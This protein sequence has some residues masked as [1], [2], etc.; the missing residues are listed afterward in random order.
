M[1]LQT[2]RLAF[3]AEAVRLY[4][5]AVEPAIGARLET[6]L[7]I[8]WKADTGATGSLVVLTQ[9]KY[10]QLLTTPVPVPVSQSLPLIKRLKQIGRNYGDKTPIQVAL[11]W[12]IMQGN[13]V[14]IPGAKSRAQVSRSRKTLDTS[15]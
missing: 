7:A 15:H 8:V 13:V 14:P 12:L 10:S 11:N 1:Q 9:G 3:Q 4:E 5:L 2:R 6:G